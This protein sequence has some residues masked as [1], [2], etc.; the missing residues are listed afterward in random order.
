L[1]IAH[2]QP[3]KHIPPHYL[4][5]HT[6]AVMN[7]AAIFSK[8]FD[9]FSMGGIGGLMH[10]QGKKSDAFQAYIQSENKVRGSV[11]HAIGGALVLRDMEEMGG[12]I[13]RLI[14]LIV[15]GHHAGLSNHSQLNSK[16]RKIPKELVG[17]EKRMIKEKEL[18]VKLL[19][20]AMNNPTF[21]LEKVDQYWYLSTLTRFCF[22]AVIDAD[23]LDAEAYFN[24][25]KAY[26]RDYEAPKVTVFLE[27]LNQ[28]MEH[29]EKKAKPS[30]INTVRKQIYEAASQSALKEES[31]FALHAPTGSGKT[32]ASLSFALHHVNKSE[33]ANKYYNRRIIFALPLTNVTEQTSSIYRS[34]LGEEHVIEHHSQVELGSNSEEMDKRRLATENW[35]RPIIV[36]TTVQLFESL[37]SKQ[38][39]QTRKLHRIANSVIVL[40]EYQKLP[41]HVLKPILLQLKILREQFGVTVLLMSA[42]PLALEHS[43]ALEGVGTPVQILEQYEATFME[44]QRVDYKQIEQPLAPGDL[45]TKMKEHESVLCIVNTRKEAQQIFKT[46]QEGNKCWDKIYHLSTTMCSR[47]RLKVINEIGSLR[48]NESV[49]VISTSIL[50]AGVDLSFEAVFRMYGPLDSIIQA[51]G[52]CNREG[53]L[54]KGTVYLFDLIDSVYSESF[55]KQSTDETRQ[56]LK[57]VGVSALQNPKECIRYFRRIYSNTSENGLDIYQLNGEKLLEFDQVSKDFKMIDDYSVSVLCLGH[58]EFP[59]EIFE[60]KEMTRSWFRKLQPF[61]IPLSEK[62]AR[63]NKLKKVNQLY[64]WEG[65][66][67]DFVGFI[68]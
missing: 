36:T 11:K 1:Y 12:I 37:F 52:R 17:I 48:K 41:L 18:A 63:L 67:D 6:E 28:H 45:L 56:L 62:L 60:T 51:A 42:T 34:I 66:Y 4:N 32:L 20:K 68:L 3:E 43:K 35:D 65:Q 25:K 50:E 15:L 59:H 29:I 61:L 64:V 55:Y 9:P 27:K 5:D 2:S 16:L 14:S 57:E 13:P 30:L 31:F 24:P 46:L 49:A 26:L 19:H 54:G 39:W 38:P 7:Q 23:W 40:D 21:K 53:K 10:D 47:H 44:L 58:P 22:S 33:C 8:S